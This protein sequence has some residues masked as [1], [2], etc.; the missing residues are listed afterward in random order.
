MDPQK[1]ANRIIAALKATK[2]TGRALW[3]MVGE[4]GQG[5]SDSLAGEEVVFSVIAAKGAKPLS[6]R[7]RADLHKVAAIL[8]DTADQHKALERYDG[9]PPS[10]SE[11]EAED[12]L[13]SLLTE[14]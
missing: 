2:L 7:Q 14:R 8:Q 10:A 3:T 4:L 5:L 13:V 1:T 6:R 11:H 12:V 9:P